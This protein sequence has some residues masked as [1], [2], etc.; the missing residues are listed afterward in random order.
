MSLPYAQRFDDFQKTAV[1][2]ILAD[3]QQ[4]SAGRFLLVVPTGGGKTITAVKSVNALFANDVFD[5]SK[6]RV[7]W[8]A[9]R[10]YLLTQ[11]S[12]S[13]LNFE[14][15]YPDKPSFR[16]SVDFVML[17]KAATCLHESEDYALV[18][19]DEAHHAAASSYLPLFAKANVGVLGLTAT[20][21]RHDGEPLAFERESFSI[22]FPDLVDLGI[23]LRP[24]VRLIETGQTF[25]IGGFNES[26]LDKLDDD[27]RNRQIIDELLS[28]SQDYKKVVV[29]VGSVSH[30]IHL[31][32]E[33]QKSELGQY[34]DSLSYITG[35]GN[36]RGISR[37]EFLSVEKTIP[38]SIVVNVD[39]LTEGYDDPTVNTVVMARPT[40][41]KLVY[42]QAM[43]RAIRHDPNDEMKKA[44]VVEVVDKLPNIRY[45]IDNRWLYADISDA[46]EPAVQ[47][48]DYASEEALIA[49]LNEIYDQFAV[50]LEDRRLPV[51]HDRHRYSLLL[52]KV[53]AGSGSARHI[54]I[55]ISNDNRLRV[56]QVFNYLSGRIPYYVK[57]NINTQSVFRFVNIADIEMLA[58]TRNQRRVFEAMEN[59][60]SS[61]VATS[62]LA[63]WITY[64]TFH[65]RRPLDRLAAEITEFLKDMVNAEQIRERILASEYPEGAVLARFPLPLCS[66][67]GR[68]LH[69]GEHEQLVS[70]LCKMRDIKAASAMKDH[71]LELFQMLGEERLPIEAGL[72]DT[73]K[74]IVRDEIRFSIPLD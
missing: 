2:S 74:T 32:E 59:S 17:S 44:Y 49:L 61:D 62:A 5:Q 68:I 7:L 40:D 56:N 9:H 39:V 60:I 13:F 12:E 27:S 41:S 66:F 10:D 20:P 53:Y 55:L 28:K 36:S 67:I 31:H 21:S 4:N 1:C 65:H 51:Y 6:H 38:R 18:V 29:Y 48:C 58:D 25:G 70:L 33:M 8:V 11:A 73:L 52:F 46:L 30:A 37:D 64:Y 43:G 57:N 45:R 15:W 23:V 47:D 72:A 54:P 34:Y 71:R 69:A 14:A 3:Y 22:G 63:P 35:D 24:E 50:R 26:E 42:M 16:K 19:I